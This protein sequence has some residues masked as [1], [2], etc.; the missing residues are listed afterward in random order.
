MAA[1]IPRQIRRELKRR[2]FPVDIVAVCALTAAL[3]WLWPRPPAFPAQNRRPPK[4]FS[5]VGADLM[6]VARNH[7]AGPSLQ[8]RGPLPGAVEMP[9]WD[10]IPRGEV[11]GLP[12]LPP[13]IPEVPPLRLPP[14]PEGPVAEAPSPSPRLVAVPWALDIPEV[15]AADGIQFDE[16]SLRDAAAT[17]PG[18]GE[19]FADVTIG[20]DGFP[21]TVLLSPEAPEPRGDLIR[22]LLRTRG[23]VG[24]ARVSGRV[25]WFW[26]NVPTNESEPAEGEENGP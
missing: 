12:E 25:R 20:S 9:N 8:G 21:E 11:P 18:R 1:R 26:N 10:D 3:W 13:A 2:P 6:T 15:L 7:F 23:P 24:G 16:A 14:P 5:F 17:L 22:A 19:S 4:P